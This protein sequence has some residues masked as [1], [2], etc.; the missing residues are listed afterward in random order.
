MRK[1][2]SLFRASGSLSHTA[3]RPYAEDGGDIDAARYRA[4]DGTWMPP[5]DGDAARVPLL[6]A[7]SFRERPNSCENTYFGRECSDYCIRPARKGARKDQQGGARGDC[8]AG[9][10]ANETPGRRDTP[11]WC[12]RGPSS[13][14]PGPRGYDKLWP[15]RN[16]RRAA[17]QSAIHTLGR[18]ANGDVSVIRLQS[19]PR[20][21]APQKLRAYA[22]TAYDTAAMARIG[23]GYRGRSGRAMRANQM[24]E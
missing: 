13:I 17:H 3:I 7:D 20:I 8:R 21:R 10:G 16:V 11:G 6:G 1:S 4:P 23:L 14:A 9:A 2:P 22:S 12:A 19:N 15:L 18:M 24:I 5:K